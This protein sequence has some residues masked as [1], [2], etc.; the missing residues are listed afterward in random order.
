MICERTRVFLLFRPSLSL[1]YNSLS[2]HFMVKGV[3]S[4]HLGSEEMKP[5]MLSNIYR[6]YAL[7]VCSLPSYAVSLAAGL[8]RYREMRNG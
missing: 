2:T 1:R 4:H 8:P 6:S 5:Q 7:A 3:Q